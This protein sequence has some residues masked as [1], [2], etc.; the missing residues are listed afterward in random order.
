MNDMRL[1]IVIPC[2]DEE[3]TLP[4]VIGKSL[5]SLHRLGID[6]E[7]LVV[8]NGS[9]DHSVR[10][11]RQAGARVVHCRERGYGHAL[12]YGLRAAK[13]RYL[14]MGDADDSYDFGA[15]D[16]FVEQLD[17]GYDLVMGSRLRGKIERGAMPWLNRYV[18]TPVLTG[19]LNRLF[20]T[21]IS[22]CNC[23]MRGL[24]REAF[25]RMRLAAGGMEFASEMLIQ[26]ATLRMKVKEIPI[27]F[28]RDKRGRHSHL[29][30]WRDGWRHLICLL[31]YAWRRSRGGQGNAEEQASRRT[32]WP[33]VVGAALVSV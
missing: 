32:V 13:G 25:G 19:I 16:G 5:A 22:D 6:G 4:S 26:A 30:M 12:A 29:S 2:L 23:G 20:G 31:S 3:K 1:S 7:V 15:I 21:R 9:R 11:A 18:G 8:D 28:H 17:A 14:I 33:W 10:V 24:T 27:D